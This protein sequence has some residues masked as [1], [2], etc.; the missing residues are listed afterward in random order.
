MCP[1]K[2]SNYNKTMWAFYK[3][4]FK[5]PRAIGAAAPSSK[6]LAKAI[7]SLVPNE[8]GIVVEL[9]PG[10]GV[11]TQALLE[12]G[13]APQQLVLIENSKM[14][15]NALHKKFPTI[16]VI[17]GDAEHLNQLLAAQSSAVKTVVSS[18]PLLSLPKST[19]NTIVSQISQLL[20]HGGHYI[21]YSYWIKKTL[22]DS[23]ANYKRT[24]TQWV[25]L[26]IPPARI[27]VYQAN[28]NES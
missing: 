27:D 22:F 25:L 28:G 5:N 18:L 19:V 13:I 10:T 6:R 23:I 24:H 8:D 2:N 12:A 9:G 17:H 14:L 1:Y 20:P 7:A 15:V 26:N 3:T 11:I 4:L 16:R 21:Q